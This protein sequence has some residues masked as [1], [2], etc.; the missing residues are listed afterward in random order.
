[1]VLMHLHIVVTGREAMPLFH[2]DISKYL[3]TY[4]W[5]FR[6]I[7]EYPEKEMNW[8][9]KQFIESYISSAKQETAFIETTEKAGMIPAQNLKE[10]INKQ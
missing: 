2:D 8:F 5:T 6:A 3:M 1:M 7:A 4:R 9:R 10:L